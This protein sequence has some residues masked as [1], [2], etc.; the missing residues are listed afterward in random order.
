MVGTSAEGLERQANPATAKPQHLCLFNQPGFSSLNIRPS[1]RYLCVDHA[2]EDRLVG[3]LAG[4]VEGEIFVSGYSAGFGGIDLLRDGERLDVVVE[5][6]P[7]LLDE[8]RAQ[9]VTTVR[10]R[11]KPFHYSSNEAL[12]HLALLRAGFAIESAALNY[13]FDLSRYHTRDDYLGALRH[14]PRRQVK[15]ALAEDYAWGE[16]DGDW[17]EAFA[18]LVASRE[19]HGAQ[20]SLSREYVEA[21]RA[22][23]PR[24]IRM[25]ALR[26]GAEIAAAALLYLVTPKHAMVMFW[27]DKAKRE[28]REGTAAT[29][30]VMNLVALR[31]VETGLSEGWRTI[32]LGPVCSETAINYGNARFK[33]GV[34]AYADF[35]YTFE[36]RL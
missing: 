13:H 34:G 19:R 5:L 6:V 1:Q 8:L 2:A 10:I 30:A 15:L 25:F 24:E 17:D 35:R 14:S 27:G 22:A 21:L 16:V 9:G 36:K 7:A 12:L 3:S 18:V 33:A 26:S 4:V 31:V 32:D 20:L 29:V 11:A 28:E 23:F